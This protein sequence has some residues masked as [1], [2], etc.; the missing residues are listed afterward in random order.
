MDS[1]NVYGN[2][3]EQLQAAC[4]PVSY[5]DPHAR[6]WV[7][8]SFEGNPYTTAVKTE[9]GASVAPASAAAPL[10]GM[11]MPPGGAHPQAGA[12]FAGG[13]QP[14]RNAMPVAA[15]STAARCISGAAP[16]LAPPPP[17]AMHH[18]AAV[19]GGWYSSLPNYGGSGWPTYGEV[20]SSHNGAPVYTAEMAPFNLEL[21]MPLSAI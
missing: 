18:N 8:G 19:D 12:H 16:P 1:G 2:G 5:W 17:Q 3:W 7:T 13:V 11:A 6:Q 14:A 15:A 20:R 9:S 21:P 4:S 10:H